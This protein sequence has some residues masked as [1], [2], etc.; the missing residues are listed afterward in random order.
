MNRTIFRGIEV[1]ITEQRVR[2]SERN[3]KYYYYE[4]RHGDDDIYPP[5]TIEHS[6]TVNFYGTIRSITPILDIQDG[7]IDLTED[8]SYDLGAASSE[9]ADTIAWAYM[10]ESESGLSKSQYQ[11]LLNKVPDETELIPFSNDAVGLLEA[12]SV[13][14]GFIDNEYFDNLQEVQE[15]L[16]IV[17]NDW[18]NE[19]RNEIY[20]TASGY[21]VIMYCDTPTVR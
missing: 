14:Y 20:T 7:G 16:A 18:N 5:L 10:V 13:A 15:A 8:E 9:P 19:K 12:N 1:E 4:M 3:E 2:K 11:R 6:V 21:K 17:C